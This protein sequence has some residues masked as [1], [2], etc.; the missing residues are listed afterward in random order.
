M[1]SAWRSTW[2]SARSF[3]QLYRSVRR[4]NTGCNVTLVTR[5]KNIFPVVPSLGLIVKSVAVEVSVDD[6]EPICE[7]SRV[8]WRET[9][10]SAG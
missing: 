5:Q 4:W 2:K 6:V 8:S 7:P 9:A 3:V 1:K 10:A